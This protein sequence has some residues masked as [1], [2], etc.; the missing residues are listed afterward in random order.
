MTPE[1]HLSKRY[2]QGHIMVYPANANK[3]RISLLCS[4]FKL[5]TGIEADRFNRT[6]THTLSPLQLV[7]GEDRR[8]HHGICRARDAIQAAGRRREGCGLLDLDFMAGFDW[9]T[10]DWTYTVLEKKN[11]HPAVISRLRNIYSDSKSIVVV[12]N[13][14]GKVVQN[15][16][17][18]LR[19]GDIPSMYWFAVGLD[20]VLFFLERKLVGIPVF[21]LSVA[22]PPVE[23]R[24]EEEREEEEETLNIEEKYKLCAYAD[25]VKCSVSNIIE[26]HTIINACTILSMPAHYLKEQQESG[27][28]GL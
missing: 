17:K 11:C 12:N 5:I 16:R 4:D 20:P 24:G 23:P 7:A 14:M 18:S 13:V 3:R 10:M 2:T 21:S 15:E 8:I 9:L 25:D 27:C 6:A 19:Q 1:D 22:G 28:T 26:F